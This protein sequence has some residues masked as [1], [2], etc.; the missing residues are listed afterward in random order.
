MI[1][2]AAR[3]IVSIDT[4]VLRLQFLMD[5]KMLSWVVPEN[6]S[7]LLHGLCVDLR[8]FIIG[9]A[10]DA[11]ATFCLTCAAAVAPAITHETWSMVA[12]QFVAR[13]RQ[14]C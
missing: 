2:I 6:P 10:Q 1:A 13:S 7:S 8:H 9:D 11:A 14:A 3:S 12:S 4:D 5:A